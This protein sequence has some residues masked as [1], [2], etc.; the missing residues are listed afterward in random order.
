MRTRTTRFIVRDGGPA[1]IV[2][3]VYARGAIAEYGSIV[4]ATLCERHGLSREDAEKIET[5]A[6]D[7]VTYDD[8]TAS[9]ATLADG[10]R[11]CI[12]RDN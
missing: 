7:L 2:R 4:R 6:A 9:W 1:T 8:C 10:T 11:L 3:A 5:A 12:E